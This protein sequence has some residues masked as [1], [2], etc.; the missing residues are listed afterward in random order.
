MTTEQLN[1]SSYRPQL[2]SIRGLAILAMVVYHWSSPGYRFDPLANM[3]L[4]AIFIL[5]GFFLTITLF[6]NCSA[7]APVIV[8]VRSCCTFYIRRFLRL[9]PLYYSVLLFAVLVGITSVR[10][11]WPWHFSYLSNGYFFIIQSWHDETSHL[12][13]IAIIMQLSLFW[14]ILICF[15]SREGLIKTV[16]GL[17][18]FSALFRY[19]V[20]LLVPD[21]KML[22]VLP[23]MHMDSFGLGSLLGCV[24][25]DRKRLQM[26]LRMAFWC[27]P[28]YVVLEV[29]LWY[30]SKSHLVAVGCN[31]TKILVLT[32][33]IFHAFKGFGGLTGG[34]L[35][36][37]ILRY[38]G[39]ISYGLYLFH[40]FSGI[41]VNALKPLLS[42]PLPQ[43]SLTTFFIR[44]FFTFSMAVI[45]YHLIEKPAGRLR[46]SFQYANRQS[47]LSE[48]T[49]N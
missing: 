17:V 11:S 42:I 5:S 29:A 33:L 3:G 40:T 20:P 46:H 14:P 15:L 25:S 41:L 2:D 44:T 19:A 36:S 22:S 32:L 49:A 31:E 27:I 13:F 1:S 8:K 28:L 10:S 7:T 26:L 18:C 45:F 43:Y 16:I 24:L 48:T 34:V 12:W 47:R 6:K 37:P 38:L 4:K 21:L 39:K 35:E 30:G 23:F 9:S